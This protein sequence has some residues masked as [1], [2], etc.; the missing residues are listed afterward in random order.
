MTE[1]T[2][3]RT[4]KIIAVGDVHGCYSKL[5]A[6]L[7]KHENSHAELIFLGD[8]IDRAPEPR[9]DE[10][11][12]K[13]IRYMQQHPRRHGYEGVTVLRGNHEQLCIDGMDMDPE[14]FCQWHAN[15]A[16]KDFVIWLHKH[17]NYLE[18]MKKL[19]LY[20]IRGDYLF[21]H[22]GVRPNV[23]LSKQTDEDLMWI[24]KPFINCEDHGLPYT[25]VHGHT[26]QFSETPVYSNKRIAIDL[27]ACFGGPFCSLPLTV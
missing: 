12:L 5:K 27:G 15:G 1:I 24:R 18:W 8:L 13:L 3:T 17:M 2:P 11:V 26:V 9:G 16:S 23:S 22:G 21:V 25:V 7:K 4:N 6:L 14:D 19:P 10:K 20:A